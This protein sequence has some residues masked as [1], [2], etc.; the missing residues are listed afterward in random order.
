[1]CADRSVNLPARLYKKVETQGTGTTAPKGEIQKKRLNQRQFNDSNIEREFTK[2]AKL[3]FPY[4]ETEPEI[5]KEH[6][7]VLRRRLVYKPNLTIEEV[8]LST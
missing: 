8:I 2:L 6:F 5:I 7:K 3:I 1:M 4:L